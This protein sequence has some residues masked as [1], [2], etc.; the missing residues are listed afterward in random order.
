MNF[1]RS[2]N[3]ALSRLAD[4]M[5]GQDVERSNAVPNNRLGGDYAA[6]MKAN[7]NQGIGSIGMG[8]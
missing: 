8:R 5:Q 7:S 1:F 3:S 6:I 4:H 2:L